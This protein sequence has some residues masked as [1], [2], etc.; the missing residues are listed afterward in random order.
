MEFSVFSR[1]NNWVDYWANIW[2]DSTRTL[3]TS[4]VLFWVISSFILVGI[5]MGEARFAKF[6]LTIPLGSW[7]SFLDFHSLRISPKIFVTEI[8]LLY[9]F[10]FFLLS[11]RIRFVVSL[12]DPDLL[13]TFIGTFLVFGAFEI[14]FEIG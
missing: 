2:T 14:L 7:S 4:E 10:V 5:T 12:T 6:G 9:C 13:F 11:K 3:R 1:R 8:F